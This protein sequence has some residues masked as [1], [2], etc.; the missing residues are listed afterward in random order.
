M[1]YDISTPTTIDLS[2]RTQNVTVFNGSG[3]TM[4]VL[5]V[6]NAAPVS[7]DNYDVS[8]PNGGVMSYSGDR[9]PMSF[10]AVGGSDGIFINTGIFMTVSSGV[11]P[12]SVSTRHVTEVDKLADFDAGDYVSA[13]GG[14]G[15]G[16]LNASTTYYVAVIPGNE[17][18]PTKAASVF[19]NVA[20]AASGLNTHSVT[21]SIPEKGGDYYDIFVSVD[22]A[23]KWVAR[24][25][26]AERLLGGKITAVGGSPVLAGIN[27]VADAI[28][29]ALTEELDGLFAIS[30]ETN[31]IILTAS[32][33]AANDATL[34]VAIEDGTCVGITEAATSADTTPGVAPVQ[35][36]ETIAFTGPVTASG[37]MWITVTAGEMP[38]SPKRVIVDLLEN[39][40]AEDVAAAAIV[41]M[42]ADADVGAFFTFEQDGADVIA[43]AVTAA[44]NDAT[45]N[46]AYTSV[47][48]RGITA[49]ATSADT[50]PGVAPAA[51]VE[52]ATIVASGVLAGDLAVTVTGD[53]LGSS[54]KTLVIPLE[55]GDSATLIASIVADSLEVDED[56]TAF[57]EAD[58]DGADVTLTKLV[59]E[60]DDATMNIAYTNVFTRGLTDAPTSADTTPGVAPTP[61]VETATIVGTITG[62]G[63]A[64]VT[65]TGDGISEVIAVDVLSGDS[66]D[67]VAAKVIAEL[68]EEAPITAL[69]SVGGTGAD[70]VLTRLVAAAN[71]ATLNVAYDNGTCTGLTPDATS[72]NTTPGTLGTKQVETATVVATMTEACSIGVTLTMDGVDTRYLVPVESGDSG[73]DIADLI[74]QRLAADTAVTALYDISGAT[75]KVIL[76][77]LVEAAN[78]A[79]LNLATDN[80]GAIGI[81][82][83]ATSTTTVT[84]TV[85]TKQVETA[86]IVGT[87]TVDG[88]MGVDFT[89]GGLTERTLVPVVETDDAEDMATAIIAAIEGTYTDFVFTQSTGDII[90]TAVAEAANDAT[91]NLGFDNGGATGITPDATSADTT[92]GVL[93]TAQVETATVVAAAITQEGDAKV[94]IT[95]SLFEEPLVVN[96][97]IETT[98]TEGELVVGLPGTGAQTSSSLY[99]RNNAYVISDPVECAGAKVAKVHVRLNVSDM[100]V[101]P[102]V[103]LVPFFSLDSA[104]WYQGTATTLSFEGDDQT[105]SG[106][107]SV[108][109]S[110][111][112]M[113]VLV[114][115][116]TGSGAT[117]DLE[118]TLE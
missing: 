41:A 27:D 9:M 57:A 11:G 88:N 109:A 81:T 42:E 22:A 65:V 71:D 7:Q 58:S 52:T 111:N 67:D 94:T 49:N 19:D 78:D 116:L 101:V 13:D 14:V 8:I 66:A 6:P 85:G 108:E 115:T 100:A 113:C 44:A 56:I 18:G 61:Q 69:F 15:T 84:G 45:M 33:K 102:S 28:R 64:V 40:T 87:V 55:D 82:P 60:A 1:R 47:I 23:P 70:V 36:Q 51:Q 17:F 91:L 92:A 30:G 53:G 105:L 75:D 77:A 34:N 86:S 32:E 99:S 79:T 106:A 73:E 98:Y 54:P 89:A 103:L 37:E 59:A 97:P 16:T 80:G 104:N 12:V 93:G 4:Y 83:D 31:A 38:N 21:I 114:G 110:G 62:D 2:G 25:S 50:T 10:Q 118:I 74:R 29:T 39:D 35:Q 112:Y 5:F 90:I 26:E 46:F 43:T 20:T 117:V 48:D 68:S 95:S 107:F 63:Y 76:T 24:I 96:V 72:A 3:E